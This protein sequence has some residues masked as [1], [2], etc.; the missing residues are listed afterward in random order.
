MIAKYN[1]QEIEEKWQ[2][3]WAEDRLYEVSEASTKP[4]WYALSMHVS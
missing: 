4:K 3:K 2:Q 1:P